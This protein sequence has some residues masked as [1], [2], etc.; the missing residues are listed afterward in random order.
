MKMMFFAAAAL[1]TASGAIAQQP[2]QPAPTT[3]DQATR[4][5]TSAP[6]QTETAP[7]PPPAQGVATWPTGAHPQPA[8]GDYPRCS[9]TVTDHCRQNH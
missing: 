5:D 1:L 6:A 8:T 4:P 2:T 9:R 7:T 3:Q